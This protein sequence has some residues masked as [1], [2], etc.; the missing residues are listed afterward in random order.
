M[1]V[2]GTSVLAGDLGGTKT[3]LGVFEVGETGLRSV[4]E[5]NFVCAEYSGL[6]EIVAEFLGGVDFECVSA[7]F[8]I[9]GPVSGRSVRVTNL[10][11]VVDADELEGGTGIPSVVADQRSRGHRVG[12]RS[13]SARRRLV[14]STRGSRVLGATAR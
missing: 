13:V 11:W 8:G 6:W 9:A 4:F 5:R 2:P 14:F 10:P 7:C 3:R 12:C 1:V